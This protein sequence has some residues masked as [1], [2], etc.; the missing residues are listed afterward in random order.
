MH[1]FA[2]SELISGEC[3]GIINHSIYWQTW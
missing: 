3:E 1:T 2:S